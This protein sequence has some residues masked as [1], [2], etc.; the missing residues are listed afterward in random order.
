MFHPIATAPRGGE[1]VKLYELGSTVEIG[2]WSAETADWTGPNGE[3]L[4][5]VPTHWVAGVDDHSNVRPT[6]RTRTALIICAGAVGLGIML[7]P[8]AVD[9]FSVAKTL[10]QLNGAHAQREPTS[11]VPDGTA[12][13]DN[14][15]AARRDDFAPE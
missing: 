2:R 12:A 11:A 1:L 7:A 14:K 3:R 10:A 9:F 13:Q 4:R 15:Q 8:I 6:S 5:I